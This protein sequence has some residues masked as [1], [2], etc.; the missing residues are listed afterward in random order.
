MA[1]AEVDARQIGAPACV[2]AALDGLPQEIRECLPAYYEF[3]IKTKS[4][5]GPFSCFYMREEERG[6]VFSPNSIFIANYNRWATVAKKPSICVDDCR[7]EPVADAELSNLIRLSS[8]TSC[9]R[10]HVYEVGSFMAPHADGRGDTA[11]GS[12][13]VTLIRTLVEHPE[14]CSFAKEESS[15]DEESGAKGDVAWQRRQL[16][17]ETGDATKAEVQEHFEEISGAKPSPKMTIKQMKTELINTHYNPS[18]LRS[19]ANGALI[20]KRIKNL[21]S[22]RTKLLDHF[23]LE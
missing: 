13:K 20:D 9:L 3:M 2:A 22:L 7:S 8:N 1:S 16:P 11:E 17:F 14:L 15:S 21:T 5:P 19:L 18:K 23:D 6:I 12:I 4:K 10:M